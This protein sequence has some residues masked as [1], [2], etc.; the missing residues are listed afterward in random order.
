VFLIDLEG[1]RDDEHVQAALEGMRSRAS[2]F[3]VL[4]SYPMAVNSSSE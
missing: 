4:G 3:K 2:M 1:H